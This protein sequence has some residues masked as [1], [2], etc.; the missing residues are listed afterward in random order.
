MSDMIRRDLRIALRGLRQRA[1]FTAVAVLTLAIGIGAVTAIFSVVNG[2]LLRPLPYEKPGD[3]VWVRVRLKADPSAPLSTSEYW[4]LRDRQRS[5]ER[6]TAFVDGT[7]NLTGSGAPERLRSG[8][9]TADVLPVLGVA[10]VL[11]RGFSPDD[12]LPGRPPVALLS[13][14][15]WR[16]RFGADPDIVGRTLM[17]DDAPTTVIGVMPSGFQ[18]PTHFRGAAMELWLPLQLDPAFDRTERGWHYLDVVARLRPGVTT[19]AAHSEVA[20]L[21]ATMLAEYPMEYNAD[22]TGAATP[23]AERIVGDVRPAILVLLGAVAL[24]LLIACA[25]VAT[26]SARTPM[27]SPR[28]TTTPSQMPATVVPRPT[29]NPST[30]VVR[31]TAPQPKATTSRTSAALPRPEFRR[32]DTTTTTATNTKTSTMFCLTRNA[33]APAAPAAI[34]HHVADLRPDRSSDTSVDAIPAST[35]GRP[36]SSALTTEAPNSGVT[37]KIAI[38]AAGTTTGVT[39]PGVLDARRPIA[40]ARKTDATTATSP[41]ARRARGPPN[42]SATA[43]SPTRNGGRSNQ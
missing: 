27:A 32:L 43:N 29:A 6:V 4:D 10:P 39:A 19:A 2:V 36:S 18:L 25:N 5:F 3:L 37:R 15:L 42:R 9:V 13:D 28:N 34:A 40:P 22:F 16:R 12:D 21:M 11:G 33:A 1:G 7:V 20:S 35:K 14:G 30:R 8:Y 31:A 17:L 24:L 41:I 23:L 26:D 38:V